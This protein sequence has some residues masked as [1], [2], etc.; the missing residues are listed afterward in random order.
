MPE[1]E[2]R[3]GVRVVAAPHALDAAVWP[4]HGLGLR[5]A[6]DE[7][8]VLGVEEVEV[9]ADP[10]ALVEV[11]AGV[12]GV[13]MTRPALERWMAREADWPLPSEGLA[14]GMAAGLPV[15]VWVQGEAGLVL[16]SASLAAELGIRL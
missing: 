13:E 6:P 2:I 3:P 9:P 8:L 11:E 10:Q 15:K 7:L 12:C 4:E 1:P 14:Q 5:I 16:T